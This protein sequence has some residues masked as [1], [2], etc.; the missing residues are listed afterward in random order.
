[1]KRRRCRCTATRWEL[2]AD[3]GP[4]CDWLVDFL[5]RCVQGGDWCGAEPT[6]VIRAMG[7]AS[8]VF[9]DAVVCDCRYLP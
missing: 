6:A 1:M 8:A 9:C 4:R 5:V 7:G 3:V 2:D